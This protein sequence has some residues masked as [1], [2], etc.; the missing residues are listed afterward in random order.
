MRLFLVPGALIP[1]PC[2]LSMPCHVSIFDVILSVKYLSLD[3]HLSRL[4]SLCSQ[5]CP[6]PS[7]PHS[8]L[9]LIIRKEASVPP[10]LWVVP[11]ESDLM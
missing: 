10:C 1:V 9:S 4:L 5:L 3:L 11:G 2:L 8:S 6:H 7:S